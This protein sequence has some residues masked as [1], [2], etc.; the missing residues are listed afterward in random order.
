[1]DRRDAFDRHLRGLDKRCADD[2]ALVLDDADVTDDEFTDGTPEP[3]RDRQWTD[4]EK[5]LVVRECCWPGTRV[6]EVAQRYGL[7]ANQVN[8]WRSQARRGK[9]TSP[10]S[11]KTEAEPE[12]AAQSE[13]ALAARKAEVEVSP[14]ASRPSPAFAAIEV[15]APP[16]GSVGSVSIEAHG[17]MVRLDGDIGTSRIAEIA[18][19]LRAL[20]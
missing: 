10:F 12:E 11:P 15:E 18:S 14:A 8:A 3:A 19:A 2:E 7:S 16:P 13:Q 17:V 20:R 1:M 6:G 4:E 5:A 9:L